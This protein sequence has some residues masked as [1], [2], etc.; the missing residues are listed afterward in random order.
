MSAARALARQLTRHLTLLALALAAWLA[1]ASPATAGPAPAPEPAPNTRPEPTP[2]TRP[3]PGAALA[4]AAALA[5]EAAVAPDGA[6]DED[7]AL[8]P[9]VKKRRRIE[10]KQRAGAAASE[11]ARPDL[12]ARRDAGWDRRL[13]SR[14]GKPAA[15]V[16]NIFNTWTHEYLPVDDA[17]EIDQATANR[18]FR[19]HFT[20]EPTNMDPRL[21]AALVAAARHFGV[22]DVHIVS[23]FRAPKYNLMLRKKGREVARDSQ[24][25][26]GSA[27]DF[28]LPGVPV[29]RLH[30]WATQ[31]RLGGVGLYIGSGFVHMDTGRI[32]AWNGR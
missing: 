29:L 20:G 24:H 13:Q 23:A 17:A 27:V 12:T 31:Q 15:P 5:P 10:A 30:A 22:H 16:T 7:Q 11:P 28:R 9:D 14:L 8:P 26:Q 3:E 32:R 2:E 4:P 19:C 6:S 25:T 21:L 1:A 18:F